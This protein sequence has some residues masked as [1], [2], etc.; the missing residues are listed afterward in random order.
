MKKK[1]I[2]LSVF[3]ALVFIAVIFV[4]IESSPFWLGTDISRKISNFISPPNYATEENGWNLMLVNDENYLPPNYKIELANVGDGHQV[5][6]R[7]YVPL[8]QMLESAEQDGVYMQVVSGHRTEEKQQS[9]INKRIMF[10]MQQGY[11]YCK[12]KNLASEWV[13]D[14]GTS[15]H[16]LGLAVDINQNS[17]LSSS[18][19]VYSWLYENAHGY[20]FINRYPRDKEDITGISNEPWHYRYVG[21]EAAKEMKEKNLCLEEYVET[22]E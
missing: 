12:A 16:Q 8:T 2:I 17:L 3:I 20:G 10:Y 15:E 7:I 1:K 18:D 22:L 6:S 13:A 11:N 4:G 19:E 5:D 14:V 21:I 9:I